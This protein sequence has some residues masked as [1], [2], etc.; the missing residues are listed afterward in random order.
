MKKRTNDV[1]N[2]NVYD[3]NIRHCY[4]ALRVQ[5]DI[6]EKDELPRK[7]TV[8]AG[9]V[10]DSVSR[11]I[12]VAV[13]KINK[14]AESGSPCLGVNEFG[15]FEIFFSNCCIIKAKKK[16]LVSGNPT[17]PTFLGPTQKCFETYEIF[18]CIFRVF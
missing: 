11:V 8:K 14:M 9:I 15:S 5:T 4:E 2:N 12:P 13:V 17:D 3:I 7:C 6:R 1:N 16:C 18:F 10:E